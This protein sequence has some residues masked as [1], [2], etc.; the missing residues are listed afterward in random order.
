MT[1]FHIGKLEHVFGNCKNYNVDNIRPDFV[2]ISYVNQCRL[3]F[4]VKHHGKIQIPPCTEINKTFMD[5]M[6]RA[7]TYHPEQQIDIL[8]KTNNDDHKC[9]HLTS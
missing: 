9:H 1:F 3:P 7:T 5:A 2:F 6:H 8:T 4:R